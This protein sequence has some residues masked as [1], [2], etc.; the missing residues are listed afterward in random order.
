MVKKIVDPNFKG[1]L[2]F[3]DDTKISWNMDSD[4]FLIVYKLETRYG[5]STR[6]VTL[7]NLT[8]YQDS[9][10]YDDWSGSVIEFGEWR[11]LEWY[12]IEQAKSFLK[13]KGYL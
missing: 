4:G 3:S 1:G 13:A 2:H 11:E 5:L 8:Y 9:T 6:E 7:Q 10:Y 12:E